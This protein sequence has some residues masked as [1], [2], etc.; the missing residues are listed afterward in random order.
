[1]RPGRLDVRVVTAWFPLRSKC[2]G[3]AG[4]WLSA[5][6]VEFSVGHLCHEPPFALIPVGISYAPARGGWPAPASCSVTEY[7]TALTLL[8]RLTRQHHAMRTEE[9]VDRAPGFQ[10]EK[11]LAAQSSPSASSSPWAGPSRNPVPPRCRRSQVAR[12]PC[13][14]EARR[15][16]ECLRRPLGRVPPLPRL[17]AQRG[18]SHRNMGVLNGGP[19]TVR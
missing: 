13:R 14:R 16:R 2:W 5:S 17:P 18:R 10:T 7:S 6:H 8:N 15:Q 19:R 1:M 4:R 3:T 11:S 12:G 9:N